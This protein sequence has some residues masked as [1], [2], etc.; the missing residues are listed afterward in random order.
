[1]RTL[2]LLLVVPLVVVACGGSKPAA[3]ATAAAT[4]GR[5]IAITETEFS[6][7]PATVNVPKPGAYVFK[8]ENK[9]K[10]THALAVE[11]HGLD[12]RTS[13]IA[14]G[15]T[16]TL[17]VNLTKGGSYSL[18]CP[19]DGHEDKGMKASLVVGSVTGAPT[20]GVTTGNTKTGSGY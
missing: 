14:P 15:G 11:G 2:V 6:I 19:I 18:Y 12:A 9:G 10:L 4:S 8:A 7:A 3:K 1:M 5:A 13:A 20:V 17:R 16:A